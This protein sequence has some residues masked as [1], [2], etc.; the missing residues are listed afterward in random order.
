MQVQVRHDE[1]LPGDRNDQVRA[2]VED[3]LGRYSD[4][5]TTVEIHLADEDGPKSAEGAIR[6]SIEVRVEGRKPTAVTHHASDIM[7]AVNQAAER[8]L[9]V[10]D[11]DLGRLREH[12]SGL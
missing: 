7:T 10:L 8:M 1:N 11:S 9:H 3:V 6:C 12:R 4:D 5:I 2:I